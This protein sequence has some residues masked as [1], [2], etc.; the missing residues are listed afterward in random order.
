MKSKITSFI[1]TIMTILM[2]GIL[3]FLALIIYNE[4]MPGNIQSD[5]QD[6]ISNITT[7]SENENIDVNVSTVE[8]VKIPQILEAETKLSNQKE[9]NVN[10]DNSEIDKYFYNQLDEYSKIIYNAMETN[11]ENMKTGVYEIN[12]GTEF[13][14]LLSRNDGEQL[15]GEYYQSAIEAYTYDNPDV[16]YIEFSKLYLNIETTTRGIKKTYRVFI[17][18]GD[19]GNYL[20]DE[21][22]S[23]E[24]IDNALNEIEK[25]KAYFV[26]NK[27]ANTYE[28]VK[29]VHDYLVQ[30]I[31]YEQTVSMPNIYNLYGA[32]V[33][34]QC[35]CEGYAKAFKYLMDSID[36]PCVI[37]IGKATNSEGDT[38]N[39]AWNY[40]QLNGIWYAIDCTWDDPILT[41]PGFISNSSKYKY[42]LKG[43]VEFNKTH[44]PN[45][46]F[47]ENGKVFEFPILSQ[48]DY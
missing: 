5:V 9:E 30:S 19:Q 27:R 29:L 6:F 15:L 20:T 7:S 3:I 48:V 11:K 4:F 26:Q 36:I 25:V 14:S 10:Y 28:N 2:I 33:N 40:V 38:E 13:S 37:V 46:Q 1:M 42:F 39:H 47:T 34:K 21:F 35:V 23:K 43:E 22:P 24:N 41:G 18:A 31:E 17:N 8:T 32:I 12:L 16:F 45:G 44:F